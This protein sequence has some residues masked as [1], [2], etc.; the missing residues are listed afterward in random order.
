[1]ASTTVATRATA[2]G[3]GT[4]TTFVIRTWFVV[5]STLPEMVS[6]TNPTLGPVEPVGP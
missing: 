5:K 3:S 4:V 1:M 2:A 6:S